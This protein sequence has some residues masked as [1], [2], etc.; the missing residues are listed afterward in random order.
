MK[1]E[2]LLFL[3]RDLLDHRF[4]PLRK[5]VRRNRARLTAPFLVLAHSVRF[6]YGGL[7]LSSI[8]RALPDG[9]RFKSN[10]K[11]LARFLRCR[12]LDPPSLAECMLALVLGRQ[13]SPWTL[14]LLDQTS[15]GDVQVLSAAIPVQG[16]AV[17]VAW[18]DFEY[19]WTTTR[20]LSQNL[21]S[22]GGSEK[23]GHF[24]SVGTDG[25]RSDLD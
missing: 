16:R 20:P 24:R 5:T 3:L 25:A 19:P 9:T 10:Y 15:I 1:Q 14:V 13:P 12:Y 4:R 11:W 21:M 22:D 7:D 18:V 2:E 23:R 8:A 17:P 6:G